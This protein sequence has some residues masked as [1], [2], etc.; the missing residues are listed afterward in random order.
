MLPT[1]VLNDGNQTDGL[2]VED[3]DTLKSG[4]EVKSE[5][6]SISRVHF[7]SMQVLPLW[8]MG[9]QCA[10]FPWISIVLDD[11]SVKVCQ[12][13]QRCSSP[14]FRLCFEHSGHRSSSLHGG[15]V[16]RDSRL[17]APGYGRF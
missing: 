5:A 3:V 16:H 10:F 13:L 15:P 2:R 9:I 7:G 6:Q 1:P 12:M 17:S 4:P 11:W 8:L 14:I